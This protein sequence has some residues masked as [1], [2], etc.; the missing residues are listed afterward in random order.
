M[1]A[2]ING[3]ASISAQDHHSTE[4]FPVSYKTAEGGFFK[5]LEPSYKDMIDANMLRR[6]GRAIKMGLFTAKECLKDAGLSEVDAIVSGTGLGCF[7]DS[8]KFM[9]ALIDN[10]EQFLTPTSFIQSTHNTVG[11]QIALILKCHQYNITYVHRSFSFES[12]LL[13]AMMLLNE[14]EAKH[15]LAGGID[16]L[17]PGYAT[18]MDRA[19]YIKHKDFSKKEFI[20]SSSE[21]T[22]MGEGAAFFVLSSEQKESSYAS[23]KGIHFLSNPTIT[24]IEQAL[25]AFLIE[26]GM[27]LADVSLVLIGNSGDARYEQKLDELAN[28]YLKEKPQANFKL[29]CG[30]F[31]T[32]G[33]FALWLS[34]KLLKEDSNA[35]LNPILTNTIP[36]PSLQHILIVNHFRDTDYTFTL[37]SRC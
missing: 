27:T 25:S 37:V 29:L 35:L 2:F 22:Y 5:A 11:A 20:S 17:T 3:I 6:M 9:L 10:E 18:L 31:M 26:K 4:A 1:E 8:E 32:S 36:V 7:E 19:G 24:Q 12:A 34:A 30:E 28:D 23:V 14:G 15:V 13:D 16:E 33:S 21:G